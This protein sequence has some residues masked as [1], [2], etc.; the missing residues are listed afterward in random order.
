M[1]AI[2]LHAFGPPE[3]LVLEEV[4]D[5]AVGPGQVL[6]EVAAAGVHLLDTMIRS[7]RPV[8]PFP[9]PEL[10]AIP[11]REVA[12]V[13]RA[14][15]EGVTDGWIGRFVVAHLGH[16]SGGYAE[17]AVRDVE[18]VHALPVGADPEAAVAMIGTGRT[19][20]AILGVAGLT[21]QDVVL[22]PAAA[23]GLG[24]L[25]VQAAKAAGATVVGAAGGPEKVA[26]VAALG[27][28]VAVDYA[29]PAWPAAARAGLAG[30]S[31]TVLLDGVGG[32]VRDAALELLGPEGRSVS[33]G[34]SSGWT[35]PPSPPSAGVASMTALGPEVIERL[36]GMRALEE[37]A[38]SALATRE[39]TPLLTRFPLA[40]AAV[41]H[42]ALEGRRTVG[43]VVL[44]P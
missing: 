15:G 17:L 33:F 41:A 14:V 29:D 27:A 22:I 24:S 7:G 28:D 21:A 40:R 42:A 12:G 31:A 26:R 37:R 20:V 25:L 23:G 34:A 9:L 3:A 30:R 13:V 5:P 44:V 35:G 19:A 8:G 18:A 1:H 6:I 4:A 38:L 36:G 2:V 39:L 43:K 10:P 11:G 32:A 16:A